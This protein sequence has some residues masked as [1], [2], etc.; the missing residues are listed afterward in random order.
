[1]DKEGGTYG[2][3]PLTVCPWEPEAI[4][5]EKLTEAEKQWLNDYHAAVYEKLSPYLEEEI[6]LWLKEET[7]PI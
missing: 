6:R 4:L 3:E 1:M 7:R 5:V 2:F